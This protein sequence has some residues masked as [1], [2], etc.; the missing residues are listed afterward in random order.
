MSL[1][2][3]RGYIVYVLAFVFCLILFYFLLLFSIIININFFTNYYQ[4]FFFLKKRPLT[5]YLGILSKWSI[6]NTRHI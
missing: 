3:L 5:I 4:K 6:Q 2:L 1:F